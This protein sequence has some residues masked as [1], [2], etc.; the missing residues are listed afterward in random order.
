MHH[1]WTLFALIYI[2]P[3]CLVVNCEDRCGK[4]FILLGDVETNIELLSMST[5]LFDVKVG[6]TGSDPSW[7]FTGFY[8]DMDC[9]S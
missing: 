6:L 2:L 5:Y 7:R 1:K 9:S 3:S 8:K 4:C